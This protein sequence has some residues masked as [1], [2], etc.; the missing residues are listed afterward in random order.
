MY[1]FFTPHAASPAPSVRGQGYARAF[2]GDIGLS[3]YVQAFE[4]CGLDNEAVLCDLDEQDLDEVG[5]VGL[6][7]TCAFVPMHAARALPVARHNKCTL[8]AQGC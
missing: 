4:L 3:V 1:T 2:L 7:S 8:Q 6:P 5:R